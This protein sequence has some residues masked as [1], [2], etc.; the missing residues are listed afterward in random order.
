MTIN[1]KKFPIFTSV[2]KDMVS[3]VDVK[4]NIA[5]ILYMG[6]QGLP[7]HALAFKIY[8]S[9]GEIDLSSNEID[10]ILSNESLFTCVF[11]DSLKAYADKHTD[12][13][14]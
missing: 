11:L 6:G 1:L 7:T 3:E 8:N 10:I 13:N 9:D 14:I 5:N 2:K 12:N 4:D